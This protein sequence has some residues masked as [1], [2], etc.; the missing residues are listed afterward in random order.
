MGPPSWNAGEGWAGVT[1]DLETV[2]GLLQTL[3]NIPTRF[4]FKTFT[5]YLGL[6]W[7]TL[8]GGGGRNGEVKGDSD[9]TS[10]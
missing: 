3:L 2:W 5:P 6:D 8:D 7:V 10:R 9:Y 4:T 1:D